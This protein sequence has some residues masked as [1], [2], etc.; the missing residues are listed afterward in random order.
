MEFKFLG[1]GVNW[2]P[3]CG[4]LALWLSG[5]YSVLP[6]GSLARLAKLSIER[7]RAGFN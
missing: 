6:A 2:A 4:Q 7:G 1:S 3:L 5:Y